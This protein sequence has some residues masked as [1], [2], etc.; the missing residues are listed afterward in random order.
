MYLPL[1][2]VV[3]G[4]EKNLEYEQSLF[5]VGFPGGPPKPQSTF[6]KVKAL[7]PLDDGYIIR[8]S[9][10]FVLG[11]SGSPIMDDE[12]RLVGLDTFKSPG[13]NSYFYGVP[14]KWIKALLDAPEHEKVLQ[15]GV[16]FWDAPEEQMPFFMRIVLPLQNDDWAKLKQTAEEWLKQ[17][18][19][20]VE[21][22][23][24]I[25]LA[26]QHLG[27]LATAESIYHKILVQNPKHTSS[28]IGL[29][30]IA[31][32]QG[33]ESERQL[34]AMQVKALDEDAAESMS[35]Q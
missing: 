12:G 25:A 9:A 32:Q 31:R 22:E 1:K 11:A 29:A 23:Y 35:P 15:A 4:D 28:L 33:R 5:T 20:N 34:L 14:V 26:Q 17:E 16:P 3:L 18:P 6:G 19:S 21:A 13:R 30:D 7:Y 10:S 2:P 27:D 8:T 24:Y